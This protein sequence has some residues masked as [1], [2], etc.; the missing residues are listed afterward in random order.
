MK[1][2]FLSGA[3]ALALCGLAC[4]IGAGCPAS[5]QTPNYSQSSQAQAPKAAP[6]AQAPEAERQAAMKIAAAAD[7][8]AA[9]AATAEFVKKFPKSTLRPEIARR[10]AAKAASTPDAATQITNLEGLLATLKEPEEA[11]TINTVLIDSYIKAEKYDDAF[12]SSPQ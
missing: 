3:R 4:A 10:M 9:L 11:E 8:T 1:S 2:L 7:Y 6:G 12:R 5:A